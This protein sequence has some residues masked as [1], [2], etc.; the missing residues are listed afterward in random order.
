MTA[1]VNFVYSERTNPVSVE[2]QP[3]GT[4]IQSP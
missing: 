3:A 4:Q 2:D 1:G